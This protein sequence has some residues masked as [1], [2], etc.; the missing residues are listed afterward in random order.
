MLRLPWKEITAGEEILFLIEDR[1]IIMVTNGCGL[2]IKKI[3]P[4]LDAW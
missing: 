1:V 3:E 2:C 4:H